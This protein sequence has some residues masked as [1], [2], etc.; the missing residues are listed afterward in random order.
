MKIKSTFAGVFFMLLMAQSVSAQKN[1][2]SLLWQIS[3]KGLKKP[4]YL[5]GTM[6]VSNKIAFNLGDSFFSCAEKCRSGGTGI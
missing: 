6:H 5:Y 4:S 1:Y 2:Q 3:G